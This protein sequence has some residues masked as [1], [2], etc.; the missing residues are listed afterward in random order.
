LAGVATSR[1]PT[2]IL[3]NAFRSI[4]GDVCI[5]AAERLEAL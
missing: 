1:V 3:A 5:D 2:A 4:G